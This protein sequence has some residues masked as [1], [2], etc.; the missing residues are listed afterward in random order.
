MRRL[1]AVAIA[2]IWVSGCSASG[3]AGDPADGPRPAQTTGPRTVQAG[4]PGDDSRP[5]DARS[6]DEIQGISHTDA[7]VRFMQGMI[8]HHAQALD[9]TA[10]V[11]DRTSDQGFRQMA[12]RMEISQEDEIAM[13]ERW[14]RERGEEIP[15]GHAHHMMMDGGMAPMPG[16]LTPEQMEQL[17]AASGVEFERLFLEFMIHHHEG[18]LVMV[19]ELF[20]S[21][22]AGQESLI[23]HFASHVDADQGIEI[24]RMKKM[25]EER[26]GAP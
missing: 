4:A 21:P 7:D 24:A 8:P 5:Y 15:A 20:A 3:G 18:A 26:E 6:L 9:M 17:A 1:V 23:F 10:L 13:M 16:M 12:L 22:G 11:P 19:K 14:L 2:A 25:L